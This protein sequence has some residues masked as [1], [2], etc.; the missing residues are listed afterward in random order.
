M[1]STP[2]ERP[3]AGRRGVRAGTARGWDSG[4]QGKGLRTQ[5]APGNKWLRVAGGDA[6]QH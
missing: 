5:A 2:M 3:S 6:L 1:P 4:R